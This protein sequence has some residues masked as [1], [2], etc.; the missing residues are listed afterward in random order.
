M[1]IG[2]LVAESV[3]PGASL[4]ALPLTLKKV[5]RYEVGNATPDQPPV[6]TGIEFEFPESEAER[7]ADALAAVLAAGGWWA[8]LHADGQTFIVFAGRV[9]RFPAGD[10]AAGAEAR[11]HALAVGVPEDQLDWT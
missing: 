11:A 10:T 8:D 6:W 7:V 5:E 9:F 2:Y 1:G 3:R 4:E